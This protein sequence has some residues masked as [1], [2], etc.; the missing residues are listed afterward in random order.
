MNESGEAPD[1]TAQR[2]AEAIHASQDG[3]AWVTA[4]LGATNYHTTITARDHTIIAD[5]PIESGGQD[6]GP[7]PYDLLL[8][9]LATCMSMT[10]RMY[11]TRKKW[12]LEE[13][14]VR[15]RTARAPSA[16]AHDCV[17]CDV[18]DTG[19]TR[20]ERQVELRG[21]LSEE[22]RAR[23]LDIADRCPLKRTLERGLQIV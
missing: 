4:H 22:Q 10:V 16:H 5:E 6:T 21:E 1:V 23:L 20:L 15:L 9:A 3:D 8:A 18:R 11:A 17:E 12:P 19:L 7:T 2:A 13:V 14:V